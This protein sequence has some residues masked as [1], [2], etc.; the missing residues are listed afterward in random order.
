MSRP[1]SLLRPRSLILAAVAAVGLAT[2]FVLP[3]RS[4]TAEA[5][6]GGITWQD[7]FNAPAGAPVDQGKWRF[8]TG[9]GQGVP[10]GRDRH[11]RRRPVRRAAAAHRPARVGAAGRRGPVPAPLEILSSR[12]RNRAPLD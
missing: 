7:E 11:V 1:R 8:D 5:A 4:D 6:I 2:A 9:G 10:A 3:S 12:Y